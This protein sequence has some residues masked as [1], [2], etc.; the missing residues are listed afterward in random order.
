MYASLLLVLYASLPLPPP[1]R[2]VY[3][4]LPS[5]PPRLVYQPPPPPPCPT[6][7]F[8][9]LGPDMKPSRVC[10]SLQVIELW[11]GMAFFVL[12]INTWFMAGV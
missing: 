10:I 2:L 9:D 7:M 12:T 5:P 4:P 3:Q 1:P 8:C 6:D 11:R